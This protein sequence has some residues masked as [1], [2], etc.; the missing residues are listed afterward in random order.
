M[1]DDMALRVRSPT[2]TI[3]LTAKRLI[4]VFG[5]FVASHFSFVVSLLLPCSCIERSPSTNGVIPGPAAWSPSISKGVRTN[6]T[7]VRCTL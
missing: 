3:L 7:I 4:S 5:L 1:L 6:R 2:S